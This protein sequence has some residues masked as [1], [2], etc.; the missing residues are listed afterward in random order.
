MKSVWYGAAVAGA[1]AVTGCDNTSNN[2]NTPQ[3]PSGTSSTGNSTNNGVMGTNTGT[4]AN[5]TPAN[6]TTPPTTPTAWDTAA[7]NARTTLTAAGAKIDALAARA[8]TATGEAKTRIEASVRDLRENY[9]GVESRIDELRQNAGNK[10]EEIRD[11]VS[12]R[13]AEL[14]RKIDEAMTPP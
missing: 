5:P 11:D 10:W 1:L 6:P 12:T 3:T 4:S 2:P 13:L 8:A 7:E 14:N 9:S